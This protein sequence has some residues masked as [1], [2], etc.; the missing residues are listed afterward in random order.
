MQQWIEKMKWEIVTAVIAAIGFFQWVI[1]NVL[2]SQ[3]LTREECEKMQN[4]CNN[5]VCK[6]IEELRGELRAYRIDAENKRD[7]AREKLT[8]QLGQ[9]RV[10]MARIDQKIQDD[11]WGDNGKGG[12]V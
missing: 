2:K 8:E 12:M 1:F 6:D 3:F 4:R 10:F 11:R 9:I 5:A 7:E